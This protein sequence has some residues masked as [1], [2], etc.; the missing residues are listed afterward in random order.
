V[1]VSTIVTRSLCVCAIAAVLLMACGPHSPEAHHD[2]D[3]SVTTGTSAT[4]PSSPADKEQPVR[5]DTGTTDATPQP[6]GSSVEPIP[7]TTT[8][9]IPDTTTQTTPPATTS[10]PPPSNDNG[11]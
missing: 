11:H 7:P 5:L 2:T 10:V 4:A 8:A 9:A 3:T 6:T 1:L